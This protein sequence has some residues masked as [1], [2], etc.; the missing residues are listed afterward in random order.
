M[1][2]HEEFMKSLID[3]Y[4]GDGVTVNWSRADHYASG[5]M[6]YFFLEND[7]DNYQ[8]SDLV[9]LLFMDESRIEVKSHTKSRFGGN[10]VVEGFEIVMTE[11]SLWQQEVETVIANWFGTSN[12]I[13]EKPRESRLFNFFRFFRFFR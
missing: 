11:S 8:E 3:K 10:E 13:Q 5:Q 6:Q 12:P 9:F 7:P 1:L 2:D 4:S